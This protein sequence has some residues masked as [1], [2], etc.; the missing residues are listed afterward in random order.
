LYELPTPKA[1]TL[2]LLAGGSIPVGRTLCIKVAAGGAGMGFYAEALSLT[3]LSRPSPESNCVT[4]TA[5]MQTVNITFEDCGTTCAGYLFYLNTT[6]G[7]YSPRPTAWN[8]TAVNRVNPLGNNICGVRDELAFPKANS[9]TLYWGSFASINPAV[10]GGAYAGWVEY[11]PSGIP[12]LNI[13]GGTVANPITPQELY[14][15]LQY[16]NSTQDFVDCAPISGIRYY[17]GSE[18]CGTFRF[19]AS[20]GTMG[21][22]VANGV[23]NIPNGVMVDQEW[24][25]QTFNSGFNFTIGVYNPTTT[26][27][28]AGGIYRRTACY[29]AYNQLM[30][31]DFNGAWYG[32]GYTSLSV[33]TSYGVGL[34]SGPMPQITQPASA[35]LWRL[36][37]SVMYLTTGTRMYPYTGSGTQWRYSSIIIESGGEFSGYKTGITSTVDSLR[38]SHTTGYWGS[39][40]QIVENIYYNTISSSDSAGPL[41]GWLVGSL[42]RTTLGNTTIA[43]CIN[44]REPNNGAVIGYGGWTIFNATEVKIVFNKENSLNLKVVDQNNAPITGATVRIYNRTGYQVGQYA[45][46]P[47]AFLGQTSTNW[48]QR[49]TTL[50]L[51]STNQLTVGD[52]LYIG[53]EYLNVTAIINYSAATVT[54]GMFQSVINPLAGSSTA[55]ATYIYSL[56]VYRGNG[57]WTTNTTGDLPLLNLVPNATRRVTNIAAGYFLF[58]WNLAQA[59]FRIEVNAS[60]YINATYYY[61]P[62]AAGTFSLTLMNA[63]ASSGGCSFEYDAIVIK[64]GSGII[65]HPCG[66]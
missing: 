52:I 36:T 28:S 63:T 59:P 15:W 64:Q 32:G 58:D 21:T 31:F 49:G 24:G 45:A 35:P 18:Q 8:V 33:N 1:P 3:M 22:A 47:F 16:L 13:S 51:N 53:D 57:T 29:P 17:G 66:S 10:V 40:N 43:R 9:T 38:V 7:G 55:D 23:F 50:Y 34:T 30:S 61:L 42:P 60:G 46:A 25:K 54:R 27:A 48:T 11:Y 62:T 20:M 19:R 39:F 56:N 6:A 12:F 4:T 26:G 44:C 37:S 14:N 2:T 5:G 41:N 65:L